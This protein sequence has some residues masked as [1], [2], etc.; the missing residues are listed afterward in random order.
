MRLG[1]DI[2]GVMYHWDRTARYMLR[3]VL[4]GSPYKKDG[5]LGQE[6]QHWDHIQELVA[7]EHWKWLWTEGVRL[8]LF[9]HGHLYPGT[10]QAIRRLAELGD[11][12]VITS[13]PKA[14]VPDTMA[15]LAYQQL[16]ISEVHI[17]VNGEP[18]SSVPSCDIYI[19]DKFENCVELERNTEGFVCLM[20]RPWN[21]AGLFWPRVRSWAEF[22][23]FARQTAQE[24][25]EVAETI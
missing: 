15:W 20:D 7:P 24:L 21:Q 1:I 4:P 18:K 19:D 23:G 25:K 9:R 13:R 22:E 8:G 11:I 3:E 16:H 14:A 12:V 6:S 10:I 2:D 5:P 17:L